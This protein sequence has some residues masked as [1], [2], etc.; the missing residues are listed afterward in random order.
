[1]NSSNNLKSGQKSL[2][3]Q[4]FILTVVIILIAFI[5][6]LIQKS[7]TSTI[8]NTGFK[9]YQTSSKLLKDLTVVHANLSRIKG[10]VA[11]GQDKQ[12]IAR[13]SDQQIALMTEDINLV[14][15]TLDSGIS[16]EQ[17]E[18]YKGILANLSEYEKAA[19][20]VIRLAPMNTGSAYLSSADGKMEATTQLLTQLLELDG[21]AAESAYGTA[22]VVFYIVLV[23]LVALLVLSFILIPSFIKK[24]LTASVIEPLQETSGIL[25]EYA[26]GR[27]NKSLT[28]EADDAIGEV[29]ESVN[30]LRS[31]LS[32]AGAAPKASAPETAPAHKTAAPEPAPAKPEDKAKSLSDMIKKGPEQTR[33]ADR[34]VVSSKKAID[35]LQDI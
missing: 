4:L 11:S 29:V 3:L 35:K 9:N 6:L 20:Q 1:M 34:L 31:K 12:E 25:R 13:V 15:K 24:M 5:G 30:A 10:M 23:A 16:S 21:N 17:Q 8:F 14:K 28:W 33:D 7:K 26:G 22:S 2:F 32:A 18:F 19:V 27:Y